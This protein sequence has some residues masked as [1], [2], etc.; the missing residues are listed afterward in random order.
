MQSKGEIENAVH[1]GLPKNR[2]KSGDLA[3]LDVQTNPCIEVSIAA[4]PTNDAHVSNFELYKPCF[5]DKQ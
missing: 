3:L 2:D 5:L 4:I 1:L